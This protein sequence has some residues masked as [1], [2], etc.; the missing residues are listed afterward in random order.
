ANN[1]SLS[2]ALQPRSRSEQLQPQHGTPAP[3]AQ[4]TTPASAPHSS[5]V[6]AANNSSL[7][8][9]PQPVRAANNLSLSAAPQPVRAANNP[10]F[11]AAP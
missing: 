2:T 3:F 11:S 5:P 4:R 8:T 10:S 1:S 6:R 7:S 9:A